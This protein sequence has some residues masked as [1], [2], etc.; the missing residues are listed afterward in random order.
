MVCA[1]GGGDAQGRAP[2]APPQQQHGALGADDVSALGAGVEPV[3]TVAA[4][5]F[6]VSLAGVAWTYAG[7]PLLLLALARLRPRSR[8][9]RRSIPSDRL[10]PSVTIIISAYNEEK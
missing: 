2:G 6:W 1:G 9:E 5:V 7:Y 10:E 3:T 4:V 8:G